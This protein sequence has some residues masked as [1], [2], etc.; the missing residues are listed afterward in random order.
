MVPLSSGSFQ[1]K[2][3]TKKMTRSIPTSPAVPGV[4]LAAASTPVVL[5]SDQVLPLPT[6]AATQAGQTAGNTSLTAIAESVQAAA[7]SAAQG[8]AN[9]SLAA[10]AASVAAAPTATAQ[11]TANTALTTVAAA[12]G[13]GATGVT[14]PAGG[15]GL[16]GWVSGIY[17][18]LTGTLTAVD[19]NTVPVTTVL[20][21]VVG[22]P[23]A[24]GRSFVAVCT[25]AG[26]VSVTLSGGITRIYPLLVG[27]N[28]FPFA[29]TAVN[30]SGTTASATYENWV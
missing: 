6:G 24:A 11:T 5:A 27:L 8:T 29:V 14:L 1:S 12:Q 19:P 15:T 23:L 28:V 20:P 17:K 3:K 4:A 22:T 16:L 26:N 10:I 9:T 21:I 18:A 2:G 25:V 13:A 7:T 30:A